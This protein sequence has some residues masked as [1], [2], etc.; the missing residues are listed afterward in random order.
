MTYF[1]LYQEPFSLQINISQIKRKYYALSKE[2]HPDKFSLSDAEAQEKALQ[3][4]EQIN[5]GLRVLSNFE[6]RLKYILQINHVIS[7]NEDFK[8]SNHFLMDMMDLNEEIMEAKLSNDSN[9]MLAINKKIE[10]ITA[11]QKNEIE[12]VHS[13]TDFA[14]NTELENSQLKQ[15]YYQSKYIRRL[16]DLLRD[17]EVEM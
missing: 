3:M 14:I 5:E 12:W 10:S 6:L 15:Y 4:S 7:D 2:N 13:K 11:L 16:Q 8:L 17:T 1:E 9:E